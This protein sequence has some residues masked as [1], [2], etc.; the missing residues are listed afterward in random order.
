MVLTS[1]FYDENYYRNYDDFIMEA[2][3][4]EKISPPE[5][6]SEVKQLFFKEHGDKRGNLV[7][8]EGLQDVPFEIKRIFY[9][10]GSDSK[11]VRGQHA[12]LVSQFVL[13]NVCGTSKVKAD[14]GYKSKIFVLDK[15]HSGIYLPNMIWK[16]MYDFSTDSILLV[17][18]STAYDSTEYIKEYGDFVKRVK[19][20]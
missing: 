2:M 10:Y 8:L 4:M 5:R 9:I 12:N 18:A 3:K 20:A 15:P 16:E 13:V 19:S 17:I 11:V 6:L 1:E 14:D 7:V